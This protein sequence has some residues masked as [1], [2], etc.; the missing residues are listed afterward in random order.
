MVQM[1]DAAL[2]HHGVDAMEEIDR[3][4]LILLSER[5]YTANVKFELPFGFAADWRRPSR[6]GISRCM[7]KAPHPEP[8][9]SI[10]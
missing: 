10:G 5:E 2:R 9:V 6:S 7:A 4:L 1:V 3:G 8:A